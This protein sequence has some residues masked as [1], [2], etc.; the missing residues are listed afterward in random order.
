MSSRPD[1]RHREAEDSHTER[2]ANRLSSP[3]GWMRAVVVYEQNARGA[4]T[5]RDEV[6][7]ATYQ[8]VDYA[9]P[10]LRSAAGRLECGRTV[11][12]DMA[13]IGC[14]ANVWVIRGLTGVRE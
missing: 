14:R 4:M 10:E 8:V 1:G 9:T 12:A 7:N 11:E 6:T 3:R 2:D 5:L 13:R